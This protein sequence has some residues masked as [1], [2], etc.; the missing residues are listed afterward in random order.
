[1]KLPPYIKS[2]KY[3][4]FLPLI[5]KSTT[6]S[7]YPFIFFPDKIYNDLKSSNPNPI[8][9]ALLT[10][11][12]VHRKRQVQMGALRFTIKYLLSPKFR[13]NE[14]LIADREYMKILKKN[15]LKFDIDKRAKQLSGHTY[16]WA[17][18][19]E[20]AKELLEKITSEI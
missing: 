17:I 19:F 18:S 4:D 13:I 1:M 11:E 2:K 14:E 16:L 9:I 6:N 15:K 3:I 8:N 10:H 5:G 7:V 20:K 12:E